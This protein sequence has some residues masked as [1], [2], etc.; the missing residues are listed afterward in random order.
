MDTIKFN[1]MLRSL[2]GDDA[3]L[4]KQQSE[5]YQSLDNQFDRHFGQKDR[6]YFSSPGRTELGGNHTDHNHGRVLAASINLD[7]IA[8]AAKIPEAIVTIPL[9]DMSN[10]SG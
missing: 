6:Y 1:D 9:K 2:Y 7:S 10:H 4:I 8:V 5:R 3:L